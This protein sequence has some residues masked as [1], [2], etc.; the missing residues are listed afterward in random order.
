MSIGT[1]SALT[2]TCAFSVWYGSMRV[3]QLSFVL[4]KG[5]YCSC[6]QPGMP[7]HGSMSGSRKQHLVPHIN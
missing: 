3:H 2:G 1:R 7:R 6:R 4:V 5:S